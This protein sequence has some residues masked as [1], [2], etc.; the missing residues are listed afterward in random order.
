MSDRGSGGPPAPGP[1]PPA[2][3]AR[4][5]AEGEVPHVPPARPAGS[6]RVVPRRAVRR[7]A[8]PG[9]YSLEAVPPVTAAQRLRSALGV[10]VVVAAVGLALAAAA[11]VLAVAVSR[12]MQGA[13]N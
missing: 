3:H 7:R 1:E 9:T 6:D 13:V 2:P 4:R 12:A 10:L 8:L 11:G 5:P